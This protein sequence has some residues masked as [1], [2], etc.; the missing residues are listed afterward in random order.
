MTQTSVDSRWWI[1]V[2][3]IFIWA[4][5]HTLF[6]IA[7]VG[8]AVGET[9]FDLLGYGAIGLVIL[10][11]ISLYLDGRHITNAETDWDLDVTIY[12][13]GAFLGI[14]IIPI[15]AGVAGFYLYNRH[16]YLGVP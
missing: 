13:V 10:L 11:P 3:G 8:F 2:T 9:V 12:V 14:F 7:T 6:L 4:I 5:L 1:P 15:A 16:R